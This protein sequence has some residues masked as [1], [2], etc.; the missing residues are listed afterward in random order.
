MKSKLPFLYI[1]FILGI[2]KP[3]YSQYDRAYAQFLLNGVTYNPAIAGSSPFIQGTIMHRRQF[4]GIGK[5]IQ[6]QL[7]SLQST[8]HHESMGIGLVVNNDQYVSSHIRH[9]SMAW[10]Y[11]IHLLNGIFSFGLEGGAKHTSIDYNQFNIKDLDDFALS[12]AELGWSPSISSG[13]YYHNKS[14]FL[15]GSIRHLD[16]LLSRKNIL[17]QYYAHTY[18]T[19]GYRYKVSKN[20]EVLPAFIIRKAM[21][22]N[23]LTDILFHIVYQK[24]IW[25]AFAYGSTLG[26]SLQLG[27]QADKWISSIPFAL[28]FGYAYQ[29]N[30]SLRRHIKNNHELFIETNIFPKSDL[31]KLPSHK[32]KSSSIL[33]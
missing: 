12:N 27:L 24:K 31:K 25:L 21:N 15:A 17:P 11:K 28:K 13:L 29:T 3:S 8:I 2:P 5:N 10:N 7:F 22:S 9:V 30:S 6:S 26:Y 4:T 23:T 19:G 14:F 18:I 20:I 1:F 33:F 32:K 16:V